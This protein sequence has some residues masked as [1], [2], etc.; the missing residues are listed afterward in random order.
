[1]R[2]KVFFLPGVWAIIVLIFLCLPQSN[3]Q[4]LTFFGK[5]PNV[6]KW[7]HFILFT[8]LAFL[9]SRSLYLYNKYRLKLVYSLFIIVSVSCYGGITEII[10]EYLVNSRSGDVADWMFDIAG[11]IAGSAIQSG[12]FIKFGDK[13][14]KNR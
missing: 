5:I 9:L 8:I 1:M 4:G 7:I 13:L 2:Y 14:R 10:Q 12:I 11:S 6:D 3:F